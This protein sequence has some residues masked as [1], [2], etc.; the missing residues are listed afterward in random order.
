MKT[1]EQAAHA[2]YIAQV[3]SDFHAAGLPDYMLGGVKRYLENGLE[4]GHFLTAVITNDL[5]GAFARADETNQRCMFE[6]V[7]FFYNC[8]PGGCH[9]SPERLNSWIASGGLIG[10][11]GPQ[12]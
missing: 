9:G 11:Q 1:I 8:V 6:W 2:K 7:K 5:N 3:E 10:Q 4:P 12:R